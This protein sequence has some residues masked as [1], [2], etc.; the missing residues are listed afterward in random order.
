MHRV[1]F[2]VP[3]IVTEQASKLNTLGVAGSALPHVAGAFHADNDR[4]P[5]VR[6]ADHRLGGRGT[7]CPITPR[8]VF[9]EILSE[10]TGSSRWSALQAHRTP[11]ERA[12]LRKPTLSGAPSRTTVW[13][14]W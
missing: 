11:P 14:A 6:L 4:R 7:Q 2:H 3:F 10:T 13:F 8:R 1:Q 5:A 12:D 9:D